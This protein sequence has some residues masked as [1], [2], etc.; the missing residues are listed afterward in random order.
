MTDRWMAALL[1]GILTTGA[2]LLLVASWEVKAAVLLG[3]IVA[4]IVWVYDY[5]SERAHE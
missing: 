2:A 4:V 5:L 1:V 3:V